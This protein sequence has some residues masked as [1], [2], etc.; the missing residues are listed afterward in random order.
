MI[1][2]KGFTKD[3][4]ATLGKGTYRFKAGEIYETEK[5]KTAS[6]GFHCCENPF[7]CLAYYPINGDNRFFEVEAGGDIDEDE[8][9]RISCTKLK[10]V[11]ELTTFELAVHG[12]TY[13]ISHPNRENW[14]QSFSGCTVA[15]DQ[16]ETKNAGCIAIARGK[17]PIVKGVKGSILGLIVEPEPGWIEE[18]KLFVCSKEQEGNWYTLNT[19][20]KLEVCDEKEVS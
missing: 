1:A 13:M 7:E 14:K 16:A 9:E 4:T 20:R 19:D 2:Y 17:S 11:K 3:I 18:V 15:I 5:S 10:L 8:S 6:T 12:M